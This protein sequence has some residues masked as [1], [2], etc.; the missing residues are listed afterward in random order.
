MCS[1]IC[2]VWPNCQWL[3]HCEKLFIII[4]DAVRL[5]KVF[6][7]NP[8]NLGQKEEKK[9][10]NARVLFQRRRGHKSA[11]VRGER[12]RGRRRPLEIDPDTLERLV[13]WEAEDGLKCE[14]RS[15]ASADT[16]QPHFTSNQQQELKKKLFFFF[17]FF[18]WQRRS[19]KASSCRS[20]G[21]EGRGQVAGRWS[22]LRTSA[23]LTGK[24]V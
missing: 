10:N 1:F 7:L 16:T 13:Y 8:A 17:F 23:S 9:K 5:F 20:S 11:E 6:L 4:G 19:H 2:P 15:H 14:C 21:R 3:K 12:D 18:F 22:G 24:Y